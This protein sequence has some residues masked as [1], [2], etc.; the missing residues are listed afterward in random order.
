M[1]VANLLITFIIL[2]ISLP[3][4]YLSMNEIKKPVSYHIKSKLQPSY[5]KTIYGASSSRSIFKR[6]K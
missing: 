6:G 3:E 1:K 5:K 2:I 4:F